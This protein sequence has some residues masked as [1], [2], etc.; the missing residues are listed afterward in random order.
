MAV[1]VGCYWHPRRETRLQCGRC[2]K[3]ICTECVR[4]HPV[5]IRCKEC[6]R[7]E[8]LPTYR[9]AAAD[10]ARGALAMTGAGVGAGVALGLLERLPGAGFFTLLL[11]LGAGWLIGEAVA[12]AV[13]RRRGRP[14]QYLAAGGVAIAVAAWGVVSYV[15]YG[16]VPLS[17]WTAVNVLIA[18]VAATA[19]LRS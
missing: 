7:P 9:F 3:P 17:V 2:G 16:G 13:N 6:A 14:Y 10:A 4:R 1:E 19:R 5:G 11:W 18:F 8:R 15:S 12:A